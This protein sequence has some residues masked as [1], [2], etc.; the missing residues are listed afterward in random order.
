MATNFGLVGFS[1]IKRFIFF[2]MY[3]NIPVF[4]YFF[5]VFNLILI[6][7]GSFLS[8]GLMKNSMM[9]D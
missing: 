3:K 2:V 8:F 1:E 7:F 4:E 9:A 6:N 5:F